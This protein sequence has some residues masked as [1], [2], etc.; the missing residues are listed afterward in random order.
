[1]VHSFGLIIVVISYPIALSHNT[2]ILPQLYLSSQEERRTLTGGR[3]ELIPTN[4]YDDWSKVTYSGTYCC[5]NISCSYCIYG[6][7]AV[8]HTLTVLMVM[9]DKHVMWFTQ[10]G[11]L[12]TTYISCVHYVVRCLLCMEYQLKIVQ[13]IM[14]PPDM[15]MGWC[16]RHL[17]NEIPIWRLW[18]L[19]SL[20]WSGLLLVPLFLVLHLLLF[21]LTNGNTAWY[22]GT[23]L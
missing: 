17:F 10:D 12:I 2:Y 20:C 4:I 19:I 21:T 8:T 6:I 7:S 18:L 1:M 11:M 22:G 16:I 5:V 23:C 3:G 13:S 9:P 15:H 14:I